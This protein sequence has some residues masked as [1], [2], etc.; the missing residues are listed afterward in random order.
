[1]WS[2]SRRLERK[3]DWISHTPSSPMSYARGGQYASDDS[4]PRPFR[5]SSRT[6]ENSASGVVGAASVAANSAPARLR[7]ASNC[8][9]AAGLE[10]MSKP[11]IIESIAT[12]EPSSAII[13]F[14]VL[15][16]FW[17]THGSRS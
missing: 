6:A 14:S 13:T 9:L 4:S 17:K 16:P 12:T 2:K 7:K 8:C 1:M 3:P 11:E 10:W 5:S 15:P